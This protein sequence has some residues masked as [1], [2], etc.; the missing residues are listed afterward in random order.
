M[1]KLL[2]TG[3]FLA[4]LSVL[5]AQNTR[6]GF[7]VGGSFANYHSKVDGETDNGNTHAGFTGGLIV[8]IPAGSNFSFQPALNFVQKGTKDEQTSGG[9]TEKAK[10]TVNMLEV[11]LNFLYNARSNAGTFFVGAGPSIGFALSGKL[12]YTSDGTSLS[13]DLNFGN[14]DNDD[15]KGLDIG[16]NALAGF[17]FPNGLMVA[18]NYNLGLNNLFPGSNNDGS[19]L[20][21]HYFGVKVGWLIKGS[22]GKNK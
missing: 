15:L 13:S 12:K 21:S 3:L 1:K 5:Q 22:G 7:T 9:I 18:A 2:F 19:S 14:S 10:L 6:F 4:A 17:A 16:A 11:P 20:K 8:D